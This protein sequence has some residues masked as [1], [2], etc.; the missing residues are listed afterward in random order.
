MTRVW[1][2]PH[3]TEGDGTRWDFTGTAGPDGK[4]HS[5]FKLPDGTNI[6]VTTSGPTGASVTRSL[7]I[8]N[9]ADRVAITGVDARPSTSAITHDGYERRAENLT[10]NKNA[11]TFVLGGDGGA[12]VK[13]FREKQ[14]Q[15]EGEITGTV[16]RDGR[17][18]QT[19]DG[20]KKYWVDPR[21]E[22]PVG[23]AAWGNKFRGEFVDALG[24]SGAPPHVVRGLSQYVSADHM[25]SEL[26]FARHLFGGGCGQFQN[27]GHMQ[28]SVGGMGDI[29]MYIMQQRQMLNAGRSAWMYA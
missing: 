3:V 7:E 6:A 1:G 17:Y 25:D 4:G 19:V 2:D 16:W 15:I 18:D 8:T 26:S 20:G 27:F 11:E 22:P 14:G 28:E 23:S 29:M 5:N 13:W 10:T 21:L 24:S 12:N 9:G